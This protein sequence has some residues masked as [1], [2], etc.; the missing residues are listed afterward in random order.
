MARYDYECEKCG[1]QKEIERP[2]TALV[3]PVICDCGETMVRCWSAPMVEF[4]G[5][6][7]QS[8]EVK[9]K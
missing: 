7:W 3:E 2:M 1:K 8:N 6:G 9:Y 5:E 4:R